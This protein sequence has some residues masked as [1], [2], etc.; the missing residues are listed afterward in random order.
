MGIDVIETAV[1]IP[2]DEAT[3][4][5]INDILTD[6]ADIKHQISHRNTLIKE[7]KEVLVKEYKIPAKLAARMISTKYKESFKKDVAIDET[8]NILY[9]SVT[10]E[11][12]ED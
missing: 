7:N 3:R 9:E 5:K 12:I 4:K 6:C 1:V 11:K 8:F 2:Q 10:G